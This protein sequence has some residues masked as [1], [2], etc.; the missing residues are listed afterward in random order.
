MVLTG[1]FS[2]PILQATERR[3]RQ[4]NSIIGVAR[5]SKRMTR[6]IGA[7]F[8]SDRLTEYIL[9]GKAV[10]LATADLETKLAEL[11]ELAP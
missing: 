7:L 3:S 6:R 11:A 8:I 5:V 10:E 4:R 9:R 1:I 2:N